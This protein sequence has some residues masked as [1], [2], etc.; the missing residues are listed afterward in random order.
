MIQPL[1][2]VPVPVQKGG[3]GQ[4]VFADANHV[5]L[6]PADPVHQGAGAV[7]IG[8]AHHGVAGIAIEERRRVAIDRWHGQH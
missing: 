5:G 3:V 4:E 1:L 8:E 6:L 7:G 2:G